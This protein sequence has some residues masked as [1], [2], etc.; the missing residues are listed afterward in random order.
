[1]RDDLADARRLFEE[2]IVVARESHELPD[3][4]PWAMGCL[5]VVA[6][7]EGDWA[8]AMALCGKVIGVF[9]TTG[10][11]RHSLATALDVLAVR[12][13]GAGELALAAKLIGASEEMRAGTDMHFAPFRMRP[14]FVRAERV[15]RE[16]LGEPAYAEARAA[17]AAL[18]VD[19][20]VALAE[21]ALT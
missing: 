2:A 16:G 5:A 20:V 4:E 12:A 6:S 14:E 13:S 7:A 8:E 11:R 18:P 21:S 10:N 15:S 9:V 1:M 3:D 17:G 19:D